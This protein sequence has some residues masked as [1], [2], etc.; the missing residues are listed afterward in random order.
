MPT[1]E[2]INFNGFI[3]NKPFLIFDQPLQN[4]QK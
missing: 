2:I 1:V 3:G 4:N